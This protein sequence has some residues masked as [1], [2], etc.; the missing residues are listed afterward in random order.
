[1]S[2][3]PQTLSRRSLLLGTSS[4]LLARGAAA[5]VGVPDQLI[6]PPQLTFGKVI[7]DYYV[8]TQAVGDAAARKRLLVERDQALRA[9]IGPTNEFRRWVCVRYLASSFR[10]GSVQFLL[11]VVGTR[12]KAVAGFSSPLMDRHQSFAVQSTS[13]LG[14]DILSMKDR[15]VFLAS[16][17][18]VADDQGGFAESIGSGRRSIADR[19]FK[20]PDFLVELREAE[21]PVWLED[22]L[23]PRR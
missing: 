6:P 17:A 23:E 5:G 1:M 22:L 4:L 18:L 10:D 15:A 11:G 21:Q 7:D 13:R 3:C 8:Q 9:A 12:T 16:G 14:A 20:S 2:N 19:E